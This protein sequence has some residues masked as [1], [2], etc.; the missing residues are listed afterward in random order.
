MGCTPRRRTVPCGGK[1]LE[2]YLIHPRDLARAERILLYLLRVAV[3]VAGL[4]TVASPR[5]Q[6][7]GSDTLS[8]AQRVGLALARLGA[9]QRVRI[10]ARGVGLV[11]GWVVSSSPSLVTLRTDGSQIE[12]PAPGVDSLWGLGGSHAGEGALIGAA[13]GGAAGAASAYVIGGGIGS[14]RGPCDGSCGAGAVLVG[15]LLGAAGGALIGALFGAAVP[16]WQLRV[17]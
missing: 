10:R 13:V 4:V 17:P 1:T 2:A 9:G 16:R 12:V 3:S 8:A 5:A 15:G 7:Q 11:Y 6:A 14:T